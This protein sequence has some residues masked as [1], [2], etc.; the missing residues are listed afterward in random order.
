MFQKA[1]ISLKQYVLVT[2]SFTNTEFIGNEMTGLGDKTCGQSTAFRKGLNARE[3]ERESFSGIEC[4]MAKRLS[5]I[6]FYGQK[7]VFL[8]KIQSVNGTCGF[9]S[10]NV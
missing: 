4:S 6:K 9:I 8:I 2:S 7:L 3:R 10:N 1:F 5:V